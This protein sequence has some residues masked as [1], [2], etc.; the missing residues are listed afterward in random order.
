MGKEAGNSLV[1]VDPQNDFC[2][3]G[4]ALYVEGAAGDVE[5]LSRH[6]AGSG[7]KYSDIIVSL[8]SHDAVAVFHPKFWVDENSRPPAP[9]TAITPD[10][11]GRKWR[12][13]SAENAPLAKGLM[14]VM[15]RKKIES[16]TIW[17]EH[18]V[19]STWGH[20]ISGALWGSLRAWSD[21]TRNPVRYVF[22]GENP[23]T[24]QFS[25]FEGVDDSWSDTGFNLDLF[26]RLAGRATVTFAGEALSHCVESSISSYVR[27]LAEGGG[28]PQSVRLLVD[29][30]S[31][32]TGYDR[33]SS[34]DRLVVLGVGFTRSDSLS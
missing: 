9:F 11:F 24:D 16:L 23:Y 25:I 3:P 6:I 28:S 18:C 21:A 27:R 4:G 33:E 10:D 22:K 14:D 8:D 19:V 5:R 12:T 31:P 13:A 7:R 20:E 30:T 34:L 29:C 2:D 26:E 32:V 17:P 15:R 1:I